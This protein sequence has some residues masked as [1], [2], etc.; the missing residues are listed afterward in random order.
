MN[1]TKLSKKDIIDA[2]KVFHGGVNYTV[3][4]FKNVNS[5]T[6]FIKREK[7]SYI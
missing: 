6:V 1:R 5:L 2:A 4:E 7:G 3:R